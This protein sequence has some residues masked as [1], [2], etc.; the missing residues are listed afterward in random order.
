MRKVNKV[1]LNN[2]D[3]VIFKTEKKGE[4]AVITLNRYYNA[5]FGMGE[6][7]DTVNQ[8]GKKVEVKVFE[9]FCNQGNNTYFPV[10]FFFVDTG[11]GVFVDTY[12]VTNF[13]FQEEIRITVRKNSEGIFPDVYFFEGT[14]REI[15]ES[16][17][18]ITGK[19]VLSPKWSFGAWMSANRWHT[20]EEVEKEISFYDKYQLPAN[21]MV[22][23]AWSD[24][25][26]F[27][28]WNENGEW[29]DPKAMVDELHKRGIKL[30]L[31]QIP[32]IKK[33]EEGRRN[34]QHENDWDYAVEN[35]LCVHNEDG[36]PY[37][38]PEGRWF[39]G[40][41]I[42]D[43]TNP[44]TCE[45]WF[46]NRQHLLDIGVDGFKTDGGEFVYTD[47]VKFHN[48]MTGI[49][50]KN[51]YASSYVKA[52]TEFIGRRRILFSRAGYTGQQNYPMQ[53]A[54]DQQSTWE[55][56]CHVLVAGLSCSLSGVPLWGFD[57]AGFAG[58]MPS[59]ELYE[60]S[61]H[62][63]VFT[64]V[65]QWHSEPVGGQFAELMPSADGIND[66]SPWNMANAYRDSTLVE[67]L[68]FHYNLRTNLLP[69]IYNLAIEASKTGIPVMK[70]LV[71]D[72]PEDRRVFELEDSFMLGDL[73]VSPIV[74][75]GKTAKEVYLPKG[76][77]IQLW[78]GKEYEGGTSY[79]I[80]TGKERIPVL[81]RKGGSLALNLGDEL[82]LGSYVGNSVDNYKQLCFYIT[83]E[84]GNYHFRD[85][86]G[87]EIKIVWSNGEVI[88]E[89]I[90]GDA[91]FRIIR[92]L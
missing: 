24:E 10:P 6:R 8:K 81:I 89:V 83:G 76:S 70:H 67:R 36:T 14:P 60:R 51:G 61:T 15:L 31:W 11:F 69:T 49:E 33:L 17:A 25:A 75:E 86:L 21:V 9:Q 27:Y 63:A 40:S 79:E 38:I 92:T 42:P 57:I 54:G 64:P 66:R 37:T 13:D 30:L 41:L 84:Q 52:Y 28:R 39:G 68:S 12:A 7:F 73:L 80:E 35:K 5:V 1:N 32:V 4:Y 45:W 50:M 48:G 44:E 47:H 71:Y 46:G 56:L 58:P 22:L 18:E 82:K 59:V 88:S 16:F 90:S 26:T 91:D 43:F 53:W 34:E 78:D 85:D 72:Y 77:W 20:Q 29:P 19:P 2:S 65:M 62:M 74:E 87:N 55:E 23:E 3:T